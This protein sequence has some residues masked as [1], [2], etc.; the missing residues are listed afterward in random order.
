MALRKIIAEDPKF[1]EEWGISKYVICKG[2]YLDCYLLAEVDSIDYLV[3]LLKSHSFIST[4]T[5]LTK[6]PNL[7]DMVSSLHSIIQTDISPT[8]TELLELLG[9][10][11]QLIKSLFK[12]EE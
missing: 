10:S 2:I 9:T 8:S 6:T 1:K 11:A 3:L 7:A 5:S 4:Y 12:Y